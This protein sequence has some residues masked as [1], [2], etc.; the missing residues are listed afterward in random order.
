MPPQLTSLTSSFQ[1]THS[2]R[3]ATRT[4]AYG[5]TTPEVSIHALLAECDPP[6]KAVNKP[7]ESFNP[8]TPCGVR[9]VQGPMVIPLQKFQSTHSLRSATIHHAGDGEEYLVSIHALLAECDNMKDT[10]TTEIPGFNPRTPCG[11]R[12]PP[13]KAVSTNRKFQSTH[14]LRSATTIERQ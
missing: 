9:P 2:L 10:R 12:R 3:S 11:V 4:G 13:L 7:T 1:S 14:S 5:D 8:R 6:L